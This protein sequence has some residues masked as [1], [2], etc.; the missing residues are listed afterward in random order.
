MSQLR[1]DPALDRW[2]IISTKDQ[3][4]P[5]LLRKGSAN[6][7]R[8]SFCPLC[9]GNE[10]KTPPEIFAIRPEGTPANTPGWKVRVVPNKFPALRIEGDLEPRGVG[11]FDMMNGVGAHEVIIES[12]S[13]DRSIADYSP[14]ETERIIT[15]YCERALDLRK[16]PRLKYVLIFKN[17]GA[18]AGA[19]L[20]HPHSQLIALPVVP[21]RVQ[22]ELEE[23]SRYHD[24]KERCIYCDVLRQELYVRKRIVLKTKD[25]ISLQPFAPRFPFET[26]I[27]PRRHSPH[28]FTMEQGEKESLAVVL[29][30]TLARLK[31]LLN[32]P[33]YNYIIHT[34]PLSFEDGDQ[35]HWHIEIMPQLTRIAGFEWGTGF[36][37]NPLRPERAAHLLKEAG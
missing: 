16:D 20:E 32:D 8:G 13:H 28:F 36:F 21:T 14:E 27:L 37:I 4:D 19:S 23:T 17:H 26:W 1:K 9:E 3:P 22:E 7:S 10:D 34:S 24:Y 5:H 11:L 12:P 6:A 33:S 25:F 18:R 31:K 30:Q 2:V 29:S 35:Y 15:T